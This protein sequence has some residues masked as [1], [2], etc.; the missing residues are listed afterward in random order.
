MSSG[1]NVSRTRMR[2][3]V[4][5][6]STAPGDGGDD[7]NLIAVLERGLLR[8]EE[9]DVLLVDVDVDEAPQLARLVD[10]ALLQPGELALQVVDQALH[11]VAPGLDLGVAL[12]D[13]AQRGRDP[14][15]HRHAGSL[16]TSP[17]T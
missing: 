13:R 2:G 4:S 6:G 1:G 8:L 12:R 5:T 7:R 15:E 10:E 3:I 14:Y 9:P 17:A 16:L 11:R